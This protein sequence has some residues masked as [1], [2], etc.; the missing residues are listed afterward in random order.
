MANPATPV[1]FPVQLKWDPASNRQNSGLY[2]A[3][4][5]PSPVPFSESTHP[6]HPQANTSHTEQPTNPFH[7]LHP[8]LHLEALAKN[9]AVNMHDLQFK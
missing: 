2:S 8:A 9:N 1:P 3:T 7:Q 6:W 5:R 4:H